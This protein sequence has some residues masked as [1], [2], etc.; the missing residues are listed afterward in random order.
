[1]SF[2]KSPFVL[3]LIVFSLILAAYSQQAAQAL[4]ARP[5]LADSTAVQETPSETDNPTVPLNSTDTYTGSVY[6]PIITGGRQTT[7]GGYTVVDTGQTSCYDNQNTTACPQ[8]GGSFYGQDAQYAGVQ[9]SYVDNGDGT[10][11]DVNSGLMWQKT[12][13]DKVTFAE[14]VAGAGS[15]NLAGYD[16]WRLPTIKELYSLMDFSGS[17]GMS[18][19]TSVPYIDTD[20]FDF[21]YGDTSAGER[22][23]DAQYWSSTQ[24]VGTVFGGQAAVFG[25]NFADG[26]IKGYPRDTGPGGSPMTQFVRYVRGNPDYGVNS[27]V[28]DGGP[29]AGSG[30]VTDQATGLMWQKGDS[31]TTM[32]WENALE[33]CEN[34]ENAGYDDWRLPNAK[35]LQSIVDYARA[36]D[37][38]DPA[39]QGPAI[40]PIFD[41]TE[42]ESWFWTSTTHVEGPRGDFA[43]Y[44]TF[45]QAYGVLTDPTGNDTLVNVHGAGAQRSDPKSGD[46]ADWAGG[47]G[48]QGDEIR[49]YNYVRC[50]RNG[51]QFVEVVGSGTGE[52]GVQSPVGNLPPGNQPPDGGQPPTGERPPEDS[53]P[54]SAEQSPT[55]GQFPGGNQPSGGRQQPP[56]EAISACS[57]LSENAACQF[58]SPRGSVTGTCR[59]VQSQLACVPQGGS[60]WRITVGSSP[61]TR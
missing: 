57:G 52:P 7:A 38:A 41:I 24:Y 16:D 30:Q 19:G 35:E 59:L 49:I 4:A 32:T 55:I 10:V 34:L 60:A 53:Q 20:Y 13:G 23:I 5:D 22:F 28:D 3:L 9:P 33:Y 18:A 25:V 61:G 31:G 39:Q 37:A 42:T 2:K 58:T 50:V 14:A 51:A 15:F 1:M 48:P 47:H 17:T 44:V 29:S 27:F 26:R 56:T 36:P 45:G 8:P 46:P 6:L 12:P 21:E 54:P 43:A 11:T 40:D